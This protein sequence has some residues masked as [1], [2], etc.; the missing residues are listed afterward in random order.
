LAAFP[1]YVFFNG[2]WRVPKLL[3]ELLGCFFLSFRDFPAVDHDIMLI[4]TAIDLDG[5]E[6]EIVKLHRRLLGKWSGA[7]LRGNGGKR[8]PALLDV[9]AAAVRALHL[10]FFV[11][12]ER[13]NLVEEFIAVRAEEFVV[14]HRDLHNSEG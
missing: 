12:H 4:R 7:L 8:G 5:A 3:A 6:G 10:T 9:L 14:G 1:G 2:K 11:I 13:Q